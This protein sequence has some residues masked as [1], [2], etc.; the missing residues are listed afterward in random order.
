MPADGPADSAVE[1]YLPTDVTPEQIFLAIGQL[2]KEARDEIDRLIGFLDKT[3]DYVSQ[4]LEDD[5]DRELVGD[6]EPSLGSF[7]R[8]ADQSKGWSQTFGEQ[9]S[10]PDTEVDNADNEPSMGSLDAKRTK[11][12]G[13]LAVGA[14]LN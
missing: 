6:D 12:R 5:D 11:P 14:T 9:I 10:G 3:D 1:L 2:R 7:D 8:M 4:E 13:L